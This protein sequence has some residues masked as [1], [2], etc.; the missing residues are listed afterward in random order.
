MDIRI[1]DIVKKYDGKT[2]LNVENLCLSKG[3]IYGIIGPNGSGKSTLLKII[4]G[5]EESTKGKI[6]YNNQMLSKVIMKKMTYVSQNPYLFR[7]TV[8]KNI[9]YPL[10]IR[11]IDKEFTYKIV[12]K[13][14]EEFEIDNLQNQLATSLSGGESQKV[15]L[16][17]ALTF[18]P[19]LLLLDEPTANIDPN[20]IELIERTI[21][22]I[23]REK[24]ITIFIVTHNVGQARRICDEVIFL[25]NGTV[26]EQG[27]T[28][29]VILKP[30]NSETKKF[31][32]LEYH[33]S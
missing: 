27:K 13:I 19:Q 18:N 11:G 20:T 32:S 21:V 2:V 14:M 4:A 26:I 9:A 28:E 33:M 29:D 23:N 3:K 1:K 6:L 10:K 7:T 17:R 30:K 16:A 31:L 12:K 5:L 15:V 8:F 24:N 25:K 22:K